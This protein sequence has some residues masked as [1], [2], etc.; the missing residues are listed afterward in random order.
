MLQALEQDLSMRF[1]WA[2]VLWIHSAHHVR[3]LSHLCE[4]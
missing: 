3:E 2:K 1:R 4:E